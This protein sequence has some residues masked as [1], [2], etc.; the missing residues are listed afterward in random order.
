MPLDWRPLA[1]FIR[2]H[3]TFIVTSHLRADC[4]AIGSEIAMAHILESL[5]KKVTIVNGDAP[6][7]HIRFMDPENRVR[8]VGQSAPIETLRG[9]DALIV[10]DTSAWG[11]LG[12][13]GEVVRGFAGEKA[14]VDHHV[15]EDDFGALVI[16]D[17]TAEATGRLV[18]ELAEH[19]GV[20]LTTQIA[21]PLFTAIATDT[22]WFRFASVTEQTFAA[23]AKL[24]AAGAQPAKIFTRLFEQ[25]S[26]PRL[27]LRGRILDHV[28]AEQ[29]VRLLWTYV[30]AADFAECAAELTDTED[31]INML[32]SVGGSEVA[33][34]FVELDPMLTKVSLR[35]RS[36][37]DVRAVA[38]QFG[39]GGHRAAAGISFEGPRDKA[40]AAILDAVRKALEGQLTS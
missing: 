17:S 2:R 36:G 3:S 40:Q 38:E 14:V 22:G 31:A 33:V 11:Q 37:F 35:S 28:T 27:R 15:S 25:H 29:G 32:L 26:L 13:M 21:E 12:G 4:D 20:Q 16:K 18:L 23:L 19:L 6:P 39:G 5:G 8:V 1:D 9:F 7:P 30:T 24:T 34:M 10:V